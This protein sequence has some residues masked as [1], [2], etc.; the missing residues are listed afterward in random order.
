[1]PAD[2][3]RFYWY[4]QEAAGK[5]IEFEVRAESTV[6]VAGTVIHRVEE[7][8]G[9]DQVQGMMSVGPRDLNLGGAAQVDGSPR[10]L[11]GLYSVRIFVDGSELATGLFHVE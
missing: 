8:V 11:E 6:L 1:V 2:Q 4:A 10:W 3:A 9:E 7:Q 5:S